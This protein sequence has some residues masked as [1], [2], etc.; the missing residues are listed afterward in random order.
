MVR[1][2]IMESS[3]LSLEECTGFA[4]RRQLRDFAG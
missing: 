3:W 4:V 1:D 2:W